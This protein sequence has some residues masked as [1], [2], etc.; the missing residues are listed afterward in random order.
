VDWHIRCALQGTRAR[1]ATGRHVKSLGTIAADFRILSAADATSVAT[2]KQPPF[3]FPGVSIMRYAKHVVWATLALILA[4]CGLLTDT[5]QASPPGGEKYDV[6]LVEARATDIFYVSFYGDELA[7][8]AIAGDGDT[9]LDLYV[10]DENGILIASDT[11]ST[12]TCVV[13]FWPKWTGAFRI[14]VRNLGPVGN[15]Y[16]IAAF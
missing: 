15:R 3:L 2:C 16:E 4:V 14:E 6:H 11:D 5:L 1:L 13:R 7:V 12:D 8:V 9:D 10:Y